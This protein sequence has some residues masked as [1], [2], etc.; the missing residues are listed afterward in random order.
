MKLIRSTENKKNLRE[1]RW[2]CATS[3][4]DRSSIIHCNIVDNDYQRDSK[5][6]YTS[7]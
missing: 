4:N 2:K 3:W 7:K 5:V 6:L 1:K